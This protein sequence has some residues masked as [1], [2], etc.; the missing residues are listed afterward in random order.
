M[1]R[2]RNK[3]SRE[4]EIESVKLI[5]EENN[6]MVTVAKELG[7]SSNQFDEMEEGIY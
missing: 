6:K 1:K 5:I 3:C 4:F 7:G 2:R